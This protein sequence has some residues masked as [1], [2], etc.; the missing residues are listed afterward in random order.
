M[1][2]NENKNYILA[3][4]SN[5]YAQT[6]QIQ[7]CLLEILQSDLKNSENFPN[8]RSICNFLSSY[9]DYQY[10]IRS[11]QYLVPSNTLPEQQHYGSTN[12]K[13]ELVLND[14]CTAHQNSCPDTP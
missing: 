9:H 4:L 6:L 14:M 8:S 12:P 11:Y 1:S 2:W 5:I 7:G 13:K 3:C 10:M